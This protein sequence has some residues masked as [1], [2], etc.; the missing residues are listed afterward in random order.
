MTRP[1]E[2]P[3]RRR[4]L[5]MGVAGAAALPVLGLSS[6]EAHAK[7]KVDPSGAVA[8]SLGYVEDASKADSAARKEGQICKNCQLYGSGAAQGKWGSCAAFSG[9][10]VKST[11]WCTAYVANA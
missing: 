9:K 6:R 10:L 4:F 5:L 11:G 2:N 8:R 1:V 7:K 3:S